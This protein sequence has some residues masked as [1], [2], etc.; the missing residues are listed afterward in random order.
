[1]A[2]KKITSE[3]II[4]G[5]LE[6]IK[7]NGYENLNARS[8]ARYLKCS[9]Q[10]IYFQFQN[11]DDLKL[12]VLKKAK[13]HYESYILT[14]LKKENTLF[15]GC[16]KGMINYA[17][18]YK[19]L[20]SFIFEK[21]YVKTPEEDKFNEQIVEGIMKAGSYSFEAALM[22]FNQSW[23][24]SYGIACGIIN[25]YMM[26]SDE[27]ITSLLNNQFEALKLYYKRD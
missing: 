10:P 7:E 16:L 6:F 25:G 1:M 26:F 17:K 19:N 24:F 2:I 15:M 13:E 4:N 3:E 14:N 27:E 11:M 22:F 5:T 21:D 20:F 12:N 9:T 8:L 23:I 18:E